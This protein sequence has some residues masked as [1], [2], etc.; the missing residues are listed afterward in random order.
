MVGLGTSLLT[1]GKEWWRE[2]TAPI[3]DA[4]KRG[5]EPGDYLS[6]RMSNAVRPPEK[7]GRA[8]VDTGDTTVVVVG[9]GA[10]GYWGPQHDTA[11]DYAD[12][13]SNKKFFTHLET[14]FRRE[15]VLRSIED[16]AK[17]GP[18]VLVG[19]SWGGPQA[20]E[21]ARDLRDRG[22]TV[23]GLITAD[24]V[25][26]MSSGARPKTFWVNVA[27]SSQSPDDSDRIAAIGGKPSALP[28]DSADVDAVA[29][30]HHVGLARLMRQRL[31]NGISAED[32]IKALVRA[33]S[34]MAPRD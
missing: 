1:G 5:L 33:A 16:R 29:S 21:L 10:D 11:H 12:R 28:V 30:G 22:N 13:F 25:S 31:N 3:A 4:V 7:H 9:G 15:A 2:K 8:Q 19:H 6:G 17:G 32:Q 18:I 20:Y 34:R 24:P 27:A 23:L 14:K 26:R